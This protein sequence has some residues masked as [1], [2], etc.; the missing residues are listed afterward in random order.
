MAPFHLNELYAHYPRPSGHAT[1]KSDAIAEQRYD[2]PVP[3]PAR[4]RAV[5][6]TSSVRRESLGVIWEIGATG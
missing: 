6:R 2:A 1:I 5:A 4:W 3:S